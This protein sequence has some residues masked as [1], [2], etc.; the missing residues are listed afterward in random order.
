M[1]LIHNHKIKNKRPT[2]ASYFSDLTIRTVTIVTVKQLFH[3]VSL[4]KNL[5]SWKI[6]SLLEKE[7]VQI[8]LEKWAL[9]WIWKMV[10][11]KLMKAY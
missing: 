4:L 11:I 3:I 5:S 1:L 7:L 8:S 10:Y 2:K 6:K 9:N